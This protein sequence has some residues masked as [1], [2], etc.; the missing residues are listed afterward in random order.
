MAPAAPAATAAPAGQVP[1][2]AARSLH[3]P[4]ARALLAL[5]FTTGLID[6]TC[7]LG[8]GHVFTANMTGN[9][10]LLGFGIAGG[11]GLPVVAPLVSLGGFLAGAAV[12]G[13]LARRLDHSHRTHIT[14]ALAGEAACLAVAALALA[15]VN[16]RV[17]AFSAY[18]VIAVIAVAMG[19]RNATTRGLGVPDLTTTVLT[20]TLTALASESPAGGGSGRGTLRRGAAASSMLLGALAG[21]LLLKIS[22]AVPLLAAAAIAVA[23]LLA[24]R[25]TVPLTPARAAIPAAPSSAARRDPPAGQA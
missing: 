4:L 23:A 16:V 22:V 5:T 7:Y 17:G 18:A 24:Y 10:I 9:V 1:A 8:L 15:V 6:A 21:A 3:H 19:V 13:R 25:T 11:Y 20:G 2:Q 12:G 14:Y